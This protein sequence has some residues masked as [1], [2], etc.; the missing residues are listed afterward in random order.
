VSNDP[1]TSE[2]FSSDAPPP[3][4]L[5]RDVFLEW[6]SPR[7]GEFPAQRMNNPLWEWLVL[8]RWSAWTINQHFKGPSAFEAG[9][10]WCFDRMG[11]STTELPDGRKVLIGGEHEDYYDPDFFIYNDVV[12]RH[13]SGE[14]DILGYPLDVFPPTDFH[15]ATLVGD[16]IVIIGNLGYSKDRKLGVTQ[17]AVLDL[18]TFAVTLVESVGAGP[19]WLHDHTAEL[20]PDHASIL[21]RG[22]EFDSGLEDTPLLE[23]IDDWRLHLAER[24]WERLTDRR[25][26]RFRVRRKDQKGLHL[27]GIGH[28]KWSLE[29]GWKNAA[30]NLKKLEEDLGKLPDFDLFGQLYRPNTPHQPIEDREDEYGVKRI[31]V[32][33]VVVRS[34]E[35]TRHIQV[36]IEG[37]LPE[38]TI[39]ALAEDLRTKLASLENADCEVVR[40]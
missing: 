30:Q 26:P 40:W 32:D 5:T 21:V 10:A 15:T 13:P 8:S 7:R 14:I 25:W 37:P 23:N 20:S 24:R 34:V 18:K 29:V 1:E 38:A 6:R 28:T 17:V 11:Q 27:W 35:E 12:V 16:R 4:A 36:T 31:Q 39:T 9:P 33:G 22:G 19:G 2:P 3:A